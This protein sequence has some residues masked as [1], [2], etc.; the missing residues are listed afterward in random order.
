MRGLGLALLLGLLLVAIVDRSSAGQKTHKVTI[1]SGPSGTVASSDANFRYTS[2]R[3]VDFTCAL[4]GAGP[5]TC[6][7]SAPATTGSVSYHGLAGGNH[8]FTV[9]GTTPGR[10]PHSARADRRW[11]VTKQAQPPQPP[12]APKANCPAD[13][14]CF[15]DLATG[16][17]VKS[18][19]QAKGIELGLN[20]SDP[21]GDAGILPSIVASAGAHS[22][23]QVARIP[24]CPKDFCSNTIY[25]KLDHAV[26][27]VQIYAGGGA[28]VELVGRNA[29]GV[30]VA[31]VS[32]PTGPGAQTLLSITTLAPQI[33]YLQIGEN[34]PGGAQYSFVDLDDLSFDPPDPTQKP[35]FGL[36]WL[37]VGPG[38]P[39]GIPAGGSA[40]TLVYLNRFNG[41]SGNITFSVDPASLPAGLLAKFSP[42]IVYDASTVKTTLT[43]TASANAAAPPNAKLKVIGHP[44]ST[45]AGFANRSVSIPLDIRLSSYDIG[46]TGIELNQGIQTQFDSYY[47]AAGQLSEIRC[48]LVQSLPERNWSDLGKPV[49]YGGVELVSGRKTVARVFANVL[50][51]VSATVADVPAV[52]YGS[53]KGQALPGSPLSPDDG[54]HTLSWSELPYTTCAQRA[55]P[56]RAYT[57]TLPESW[58]HGNNI[59]L[60]AVLIPQQ[61]LF[62]P[63]AECGSATCAANNSLT[64]GGV[65]YTPLSYITVTPVRLTFYDKNDK[66]VNP[67]D[68]A[69]VF[70]QARYLTPGTVYFANGSS[71]SSYAGVIDISDEVFDSDLTKKEVCSEALDDLEDWA[72]DNPH[73]DE[74]VGVFVSDSLVCPGTSDGG[75][76]LISDHESFSVVAAN[77]PLT[78][79]AHEMFHGMG[80]VHAD[81]ACGGNSNG[82]VGENWPPDQRGQIHGIGLDTR[83]GSGA[84]NGPYR[85]LVPA[86]LVKDNPYGQPGEW[87]DFMSYCWNKD[88]GNVWISDGGWNATLGGLRNFQQQMGRLSAAFRAASAGATLRVTAVTSG[89]GVRILRVKPAT[90][91]KLRGAP[92]SY[93][94]VVRGGAGQVVSDT[95]M[96]ASVAHTHEGPAPALLKAEVTAEGAA[97]LEIILDGKVVARRLRSPSA[98][99]VTV[100][101]P[102]AGAVVGRGRSV[103]VRWHAVDADRGTLGA[104]I[105]YLA[106]GGRRWRE[107]FS[108][109]SHDRV[110]LPSGL[111]AGSHRARIRV[112]INDGFDESAAVSGIFTAAG[113]PPTVRISSPA[114][115]Q[116]VL[117][118]A[119]LYLEGSAYDD[120][121]TRLRGKQL[122]WFAGAR[123]LG[124]GSP[125]GVTAVP[126][127]T[128]AIRL[129]ARDAHG[130]RASATVPIRLTAAAPHVLALRVAPWLGRTATRL[131]LRLATTVPAQVSVAGRRFHL[132]RRLRRIVLPVQAGRKPLRL[133]LQLAA[134]GR[135]TATTL[136][137]RR[138]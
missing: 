86:P 122:Q 103:V 26:H 16:A 114:T 83:A 135:S 22:D 59:D 60:K 28:K 29:T 66:Q 110:T 132:D 31:E 102:R 109:P 65:H 133:R 111:F 123:R 8:T 35:D 93:R 71:D 33:V 9:F 80:R 92:S 107:I 30:K 40:S 136:V 85:V 134:G 101:A 96:L 115:G 14:I 5:A 6:G 25:A 100:V 70:A 62:G 126:A 116:R 44:A 129:V 69:T 3:P 2:S 42:T 37:P 108:G 94:L 131:S 56:K 95:A 138:R 20:Q 120:A 4:D 55:N 46:V 87:I 11:T 117:G 18:Q 97:G 7:T 19:Y 34:A 98:P 15:D 84:G 41:S 54:A 105:D 49:N 67:P 23:G 13:T 119:G 63:G 52:L 64:L 10:P 51:P 125:L 73:G 1:T 127:G 57:F 89:S 61:V 48:R 74:T 43:V 106:N 88:P 128:R 78:S 17:V 12:P 32:K 121:G 124:W 76:H 79:V 50:A 75:S 104:K 137:V 77:R 99:K 39:F 36:N 90:G 112:R 68:P 118:D 91:N 24:A 130:R 58:T 82:Q 81:T 47:N 27:H 21:S 72:D 53:V 45:A 38:L 113:R